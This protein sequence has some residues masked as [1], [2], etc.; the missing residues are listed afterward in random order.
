MLQFPH[1]GYQIHRHYDP[2]REGSMSL[3]HH[4]SIG[5]EGALCFGPFNT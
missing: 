1:H 2:D 5:R 4:L 3:T